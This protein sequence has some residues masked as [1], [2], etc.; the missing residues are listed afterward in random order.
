MIISQRSSP[1][2]ELTFPGK[3]GN[4]SRLKHRTVC[5]HSQRANRRIGSR[6]DRHLLVPIAGKQS[7][8]FRSRIAA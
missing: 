4:V 8:K 6:R 2:V 7:V 5:P 1:L 3:P